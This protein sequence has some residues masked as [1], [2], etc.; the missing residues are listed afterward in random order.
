GVK[1]ELRQFLPKPLVVKDG[2]RFVY[3]N[4]IEHSIGRVKPFYGNFMYDVTNF[5]NIRFKDTK[6]IR[7]S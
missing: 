6:C 2:D 5:H 4:D 1:K 7:I 3:D